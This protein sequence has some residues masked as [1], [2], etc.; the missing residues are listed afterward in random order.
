MPLLPAER[1]A[2]CTGS[3][4]WGR[5]VKGSGPRGTGILHGRTEVEAEGQHRSR[6]QDTAL[7]KG[8]GGLGLGGVRGLGGGQGDTVLGSV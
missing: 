7:G 2:W 5:W 4:P 6:S 8:R 3:P 1:P